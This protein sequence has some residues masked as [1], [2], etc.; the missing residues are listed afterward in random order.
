M[1][2]KSVILIVD[3]QTQNIELL[4]AYLAPQDYE[5]VTATSGEEALRKLSSNQIDLILLDI[6]MPGMDGFEVTRRIRQDDM[7]RLLP[8]IIVTIL[9]EA[10]DRI[11]GIEA[12]C[13]EFISKPIDKTELLARVRSLLK[14]KAYNDLSSSYRNE[15]ETE[16]I[17]RTDEL[18]QALENL[19][20]D[21]IERK[22]VEE[23]LRESEEKFR[24]L[25]D[26]IPAA[27]MLYQDDLGFTR[28]EPPR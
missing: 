10:E 4:E 6:M 13:D 26:S 5:I 21:I 17:R 20:L 25:A 7:H 27:V 23:A 1:K 12:G 3:D 15:L 8:I 18:K 16:V 2:D 24:V 14:V 28:T 11:K 22:R 9:Q 19:Q